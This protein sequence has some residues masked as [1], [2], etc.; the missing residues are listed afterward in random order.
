MYELIDRP[1]IEYLDGRPHPKMSPKTSHGL[2]Q[3]AICGILT[4]A[5]GGRGIAR[6]VLDV[7][8]RAREVHAFTKSGAR[9]FRS[10]EHFSDP[11]VPWLEFDVAAAFRFLDL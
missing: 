10:G 2:V 11:V 6:I 7:D 8:P 3:G 1:E 5:G 4:E 9:T